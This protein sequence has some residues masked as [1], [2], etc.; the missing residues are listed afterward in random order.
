MSEST[1]YASFINKVTAYAEKHQ[2]IK[3]ESH[4]VVGL[5]GGV[6]SVCLFF[7]CMNWMQ[8]KKIKNVSVVHINHMLRGQDAIEDKQFV[9]GI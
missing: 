3:K 9:M 6:D 7:V 1:S 5:S 8:R 4:I 2:L